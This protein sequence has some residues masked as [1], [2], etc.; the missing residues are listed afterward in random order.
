MSEYFDDGLYGFLAS[1][2][3]VWAN[4]PAHQSGPPVSRVN[5]LLVP[6]Y[7]RPHWVRPS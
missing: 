1:R 7:R 4:V 3:T 5:L 6:R 2:Y